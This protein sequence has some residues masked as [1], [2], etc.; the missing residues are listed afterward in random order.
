MSWPL[1]RDLAHSGPMHRPDGR[2]NAWILA[3]AGET[4]WGDPARLF[5]APAF[6]PLPDALAFSE[7]LLLPASV[8]APLQRLFG[9]VLPTTWPSSGA[10]SSRASPRRP[11]CA[12]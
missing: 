9:P 10:C 7:N 11:S 8:V 6:H 5:Q 12:G 4:A 1:A 3:W 2:L